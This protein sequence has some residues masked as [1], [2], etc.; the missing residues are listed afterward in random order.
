MLITE[1]IYALLPYT[2]S[3]FLLIVGS[4]D[5]FREIKTKEYKIA[6]TKLL[7]GIV[8]LLLGA[9]ILYHCHKSKS[10]IRARWH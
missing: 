4:F 2:A 1:E 9:V 5:V 10:V 8:Y 6:E 7:D 3:G